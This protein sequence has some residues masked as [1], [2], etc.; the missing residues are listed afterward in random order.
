M[1][2]IIRFVTWIFSKVTRREIEQIIQDLIEVLANPIPGLSLLNFLNSLLFYFYCNIFSHS[3]ATS[4]I[5][6]CTDKIPNAAFWY[7]SFATAAA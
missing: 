3:F 6:S 4:S 5:A 2:K 1:K 7:P